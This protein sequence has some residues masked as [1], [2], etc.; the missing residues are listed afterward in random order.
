MRGVSGS[1]VRCI[2]IRILVGFA[3]YGIYLSKGEGHFSGAL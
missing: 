2:V 3:A 1:S